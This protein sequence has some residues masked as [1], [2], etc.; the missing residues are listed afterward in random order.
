MSKKEAERSSDV[1]TGNF[2]IHSISVKALFDSGAT[3]SFISS[4]V[5]KQLGLVESNS[6]DL[7][8]S[9]PTGEFVRCTKMHKGLPLSI[10]EIDFP[11]DL[12]EFEL[13]DL[14]VIL[15]IDWLAT[16]KGKIDCEI[17]K[18]YLRS[19]MGKIV[20]Y[21]RFGK[22]KDLEMRIKVK[23]ED[24]PIVNEF[25][26]VFPKEI[27]GMPPKR[28]VEFT[29]DLVPGTTS[30]SK[31]PYRMA[32]AEMGDYA[33]W[34]NQCTCNFMDLM[35]RVFHEYLDKFVVV[36]IDDILVYSKSEEEH[37]EH[38]RAVLRTLRDNK[39]YAN[40]FSKCEF[41]LK[42]VAFL[43]HYVSKEGVF[44]DPTKVQA[45]IEWP[46]PKNVSDIRSILGLAGYYRRFVKDF[47]KIARP[48]TTLMKKERSDGFE[49]YSDASKNGLGCVLQQNGKVIAYASR[50]LKSHEVNYPTHDLELATIVF[51]LKIWRHYLYGYH[52]GKANVVADALSRKSSH[53]VN[54]LIVPD[55]LCEDMKRLNLEV[56]NYGEVGA[57]LSALSL[58]NS[59]LDEIKESQKGDEG[60]QSIKEKMSQGKNVDFKIHHDGS[61]SCKERW[62]IPEKC[63][64][65]KRKNHGRKPQYSIFCAPRRGQVVQGLERVVLVAKH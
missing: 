34:V 28:E 4:S 57:R 24:V 42:K 14:D 49:V 65:L 48:L 51:A 62:C 47:S 30:I 54:A 11:S 18:V 60:I 2:S 15:G 32:P 1:V 8:I 29:I 59:L 17:Q 33:F 45:V 39:L 21:R 25:L 40:K 9:L 16:Y 61:L 50:Q 22:P 23:V 26:D 31:A 36:F 12:I 53:G 41:W 5:V 6:I 58:G 38:L 7:P 63:E 13:G 20:S 10:G 46:T 64:D 43:G 19:L 27:S 37:N 55:K 44:V 3:Y 56:V 35:N 52:E